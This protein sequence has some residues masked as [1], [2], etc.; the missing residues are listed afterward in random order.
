[1][2][3]IEYEHCL[4]SHQD[5]LQLHCSRCAAAALGR[6]TSPRKAAAARRNGAKGGRPRLPQPS[7]H[8][9]QRP[10][11]KT[12]LARALAIQRQVRLK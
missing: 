5:A 7:R 1:M 9:K 3:D 2:T 10:I 8:G 4:G 12:A 11:D 6:R